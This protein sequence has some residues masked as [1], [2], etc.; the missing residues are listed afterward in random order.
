MYIITTNN[1]NIHIMHDDNTSVHRATVVRV[2]ILLHFD[3]SYVCSR[4]K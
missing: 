3:I 1:N 4:K 2:E